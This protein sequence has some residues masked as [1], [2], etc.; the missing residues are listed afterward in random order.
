MKNTYLF[1]IPLA[2][3]VLGCSHQKKDDIIR[4]EQLGIIDADVKSED[5]NLKSKARYGD[6]KPGESEKFERA[7]ENA[8]PLIPHTTIGFFPIKM[9]NNIC[10]SCHL[11]EKAEETGAVKLPDTHYTNLR[12]DMVEED[13]VLEFED[14]SIIHL[15][16]LDEPGH[17][18]FNC[19]QCHVPQTQVSVNIENLFTPDFREEFGLEKS[20]LKDNLE[21]GI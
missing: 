5:T 12:P 1:I 4:D 11:P 9:D 6:T 20:N 21:E 13:G 2:V 17:A 16:D 14:E 7:F 15:E 10:F 19:S 8:P 18:Y 3:M